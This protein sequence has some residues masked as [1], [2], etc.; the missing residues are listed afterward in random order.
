MTLDQSALPECSNA[1]RADRHLDPLRSGL[2]LVVQVLD[3]DAGRPEG[4]CGP[5]QPLVVND[6]QMLGSLGAS[7]NVRGPESSG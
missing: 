1:L 6:W 5:V 3:R 2:Q 7:E 4:R